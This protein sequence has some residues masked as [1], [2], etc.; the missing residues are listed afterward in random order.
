MFIIEKLEKTVKEKRKIEAINSCHTTQQWACSQIGIH[1]FRIC[2]SHMC[3]WVIIFLEKDDFVL[4]SNLFYQQCIMN[5]CH[6]IHTG[7]SLKN[8]KKTQCLDTC[9]GACKDL[10]IGSN[11]VIA[12]RISPG[13][14]EW[15]QSVSLEPCSVLDTAPC[16]LHAVCHWVLTTVRWTIL[17]TR[18][19]AEA[20]RE[21]DTCCG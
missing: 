9:N 16:I 19:V 10:L 3:A 21:E 8:K 2:S 5:I 13:I 18:S 20:L 15:E 6:C 12:T 7:L 17:I 1:P 11:P 14:G 4:F